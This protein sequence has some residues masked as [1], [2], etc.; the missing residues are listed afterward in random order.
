MT[1]R[2]EMMTIAS[3]AA[4]TTEIGTSLLRPRARLDPPTA[5]TNRISSV[6]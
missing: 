2:Y 3:S 5:T 6:A 4:T 1:W